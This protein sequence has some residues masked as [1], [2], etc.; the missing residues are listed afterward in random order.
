[1]AF[2]L[3]IAMESVPRAV[4]SVTLLIGLSIA[5]RSLPLAVLILPSHQEQ[6]PTVEHQMLKAIHRAEVKNKVERLIQST[7]TRDRAWAAYFIGEYGL[8]DFAP[9]LIELLNPNS[10]EPD[11]ETGYV[12][13]AVLDSLIRLRISVPAD[14]VMPLY[15]SFSDETLIIL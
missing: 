8:K 14:K 1:M 6:T 10:L 4:A 15:K 11:W 9:A 2:L 12:Y 3:S 13:R 5:A 7:S